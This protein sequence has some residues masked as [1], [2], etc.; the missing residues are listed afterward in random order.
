MR[1]Q[2]GTKAGQLCEVDKFVLAPFHA[3]YAGIG[4]TL[5]SSLYYSTIDSTTVHRLIFTSE[6]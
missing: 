3:V 6:T 4:G 1:V 2:K 5:L